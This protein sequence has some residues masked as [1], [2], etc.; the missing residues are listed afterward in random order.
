MASYRA[1]NGVLLTLEHF[2]KTRMPPELD[3]GAVNAEVKVLSSADMGKALAGNVLGIYI[4]RYA[5]DPHGRARFFAPQ[6]T[7]KNSGPAAELP[8][9]LH[10]LLIASATSASIEANIMSWAMLALANESQ[11]D[12]SHLSEFDEG[13]SERESITVAP[14]D[15]TADELMRIWDLF[16]MSYTSSVPYIVR[17]VRMRLNEQITEGPAVVSRVFP[18]GIAES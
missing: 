9:N 6:G 18:T 3:G 14:E 5:I 4:H 7:N 8:V 16:G 2:F 11:F 13:W 15:L 12:I 10:V 17:T 1:V